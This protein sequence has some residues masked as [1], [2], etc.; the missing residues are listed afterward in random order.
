[1]LF[2]GQE[3]PDVVRDPIMESW[4]R[5]Y[6]QDV[7]PCQLQIPHG[8]DVDFGGLLH[9]AAGPVLDSLEGQLA[10]EPVSII[11]TDEHGRVLDRRAGNRRL[12]ENLDRIQLAPGA[13][14]SEEHVG[15]NGIGTASANGLPFRVFGTE[16]YA[17]WLRGLSCAGAPI[18]H[19][20]TRRMLGVLD[21]TCFAEQGNAVLCALDRE[22][23]SDIERRLLE[24]TSASEH[25]LF[26]AFR[27]ACSHTRRPILCMTDDVLMANQ[28]ASRT[29]SPPDQQTLLAVACSLPPGEEDWKRTVDL[30]GGP[31]VVRVTAVSH[32][33]RAAGV[34]VRVD[35]AG[36]RRVAARLPSTDPPS[37]LAGRSVAWRR[38][39]SEACAGQ[40]DRR[41]VL[42]TG[43]PGVGKS[44]LVMA[45]H[46]QRLSRGEL[47]VVDLEDTA[48]DE[49]AGLE[50]AFTGLTDPSMTADD[51][52]LLRH[53]QA[54][55]ASAAMRM[56]ELLE[57]HRSADDQ[58][59]LAVT[60]TLDGRPTS[61]HLDPIL[62]LLGR[63]V[64]V[65]PLRYRVEDLHE[66]VPV[67][68]RRIAGGEYRVDRDV[69]QL[70]L[71]R[72]WPGNVA[73]LERVLTAAAKASWTRNISVRDLPA[74]CH[75]TS[76]RTLTAMEAMERDAIV[77][78]LIRTSGNV[79]EAADRLG[80]SRATAYRRIRT[81]GIDCGRYRTAEQ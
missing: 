72:R 22:A 15:T 37:T 51:T 64:E 16:H 36:S 53:L 6:S 24:L 5:C 52:V 20:V 23:A 81:F 38:A 46:Q 57:Q 1:M 60:L 56:A 63:P 2:Q 78:A 18:R 25:A 33:A 47:R 32:G 14:Y 50:A 66:L 73:E 21:L 19:P 26:R 59:R 70:L 61:P 74:D 48:S 27:T 29:L 55:D 79:T 62:R 41:W 12:N 4:Q 13:S 31:V 39:W 54:L 34:I 44:A 67:L 58:P 7:D 75:A 28:V 49:S 68:L 42:M 77:D 80:I 11:L 9:D 30:S 45:V 71:H 76:P 17:E 40:C 35:D 65:P 8:L 3:P 69:M 43:E 10:D